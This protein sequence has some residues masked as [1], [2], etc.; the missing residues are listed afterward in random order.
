[1][2]IDRQGRRTEV[3]IPV[4]LTTVLDSHDGMIVDLSEMGAQVSGYAL[5]PGTRFHIEYRG[6][7]V[8][9]LCRWSEVDRMGIQFSYPLV[10]GP[11]LACLLA[12]RAEQA[13]ALAPM[14]APPGYA[15][16]PMRATTLAGRTFGRAQLATGFGRRAC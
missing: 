14:S 9:A 3:E 15:A 2:Q 7:T 8:Y 12:A 5:A 4:T 13:P 11:L 1:M 10:E 6:Q 16:M